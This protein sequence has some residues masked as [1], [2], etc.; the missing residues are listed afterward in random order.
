MHKSIPVLLFLLSACKTAYADDPQY[1]N[2][3]EP[4]IYD[5]HIHYDWDVWE[6]LPPDQAVQML[7]DEGIERA[8][9]KTR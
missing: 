7:R 8:K 5:A 2:D 6:S 1:A 9:T 4:I 3:L